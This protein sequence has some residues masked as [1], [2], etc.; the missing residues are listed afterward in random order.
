CYNLESG[1][2]DNTVDAGLVPLASLGDRVWEDSNGDG[3]QNNGESGIPDATV[4]LY[5]CVNNA[6][7]VLVGETTTDAQG[8][9]SF[10]NLQPGEYIV[11]FITPN[12]FERTTANVGADASDSDAGTGGLSGCYELSPGENEDTV[13]AGFY[14][15][16]AIGDRVWSDLDG[17]GQQDAG[18]PG[19]AGVTVELYACDANGQPTGSA[20][21]SATTD[22]SGNYSFTGLKPGDYAVKFITPT[23]YTLT[24]ANVGAD[25]SD[26]DAGVGGLSGC[27]NLE[28]GETD[29]TVDAGLVQLR[30]GIDIEKT[31]NGASN[32]N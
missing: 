10:T 9:Y 15:P 7:G 29:N 19:V 1:E 22:G 4:K 32:S 28:S 6:P 23:G 30:P 25:G 18:E 3:Q 17:D 12:G 2:T 16:A 8:N 13:D 31:T 11:E 20:L 5:T 26:S 21:A 14:K 27:Y 24:S